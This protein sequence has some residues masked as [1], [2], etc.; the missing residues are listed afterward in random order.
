MFNK[1]LPKGKV[2]KVFV[3]FL[4]ILIIIFV[5]F[6]IF[7]YRPKPEK[8]NYG[9]SFNV[10]YAIELGLDW[11]EAYIATLD[12]LG[13]DRVRLAAQWSFVEPQKDVYDLSALDFQLDE[14]EKRDV[15]VILSV[16]RRTPRWPECHVPE[17]ASEM[18]DEE[19]QAEVSE[20]IEIIVKRYKGYENISYWQIENE[21]YL[22]VF[23]F[24]HCGE[25]DEEFLDAEI[26]LVRE[27]DENRPLLLTD[28]GNLG[29][30]TEAYSRGDAFG[31]SVYLYFWNPYIGRFRSIL[32]PSFYRA[33]TNLMEM[34]HGKKET[35]LIELSLEPWLIQPLVKTP[36]ETQ[37]EMMDLERMENILEYGKKTRLE[38]QY[39]WGVEWWYWLKEKKDQP[40][41]WDFMKE[42]LINNK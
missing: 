23:A 19:W 1:L 11:Q 21:P 38:N 12:D 7:S 34:I 9:T 14:A 8:I 41:V 5:I 18:S 15:D 39:L 17:W 29:R 3:I 35:F 26:A 36:V 24:E 37:L 20:L 4:Y 28:S 10:P 2:K 13:M 33:K 40:E 25:L 16:G 42:Y 27:I 30:W 6:E 22:E 32:P 31:T